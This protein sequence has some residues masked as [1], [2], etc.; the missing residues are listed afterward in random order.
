M[1]APRAPLEVAGPAPSTK[2]WW[3][4]NRA[5]LTLIGTSILIPELLTGS[6]PVVNL[7]NPIAL[8]FLVGLYGGGSLAI[9]EVAVRWG[10]GWGPV[11]ALGGAYGIAEEGLGTKTFFDPSLAHNTFPAPW[12]HW[13][14][15]NW[16]WSVQLT[17]FHAVFSIALPILLVGLVYPETR[18]QRL[19][20]DRGLRWVGVAYGTTVAAMFGLF[21]R[22]YPVAPE[23]FVA[24]LVAIA[25]L[26]GVAARMPAGWVRPRTERP[27][28][29][30]RSFAWAG[31][32]Y[33]WLS[34][35]IAFLFGTVTGNVLATALAQIALG[36]LTLAWL[37]RHLGRSDHARH[38][39]QLAAGLI[40]FLLLFAL[41]EELAGDYGA[42]LAIGA[43]VLLIWRAHAAVGPVEPAGR[44]IGAPPPGAL[45]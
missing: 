24:A 9:R 3:N 1:H 29:P 40:S 10:R 21:D 19:L 43:A 37:L 6:T 23:L 14:G 16:D 27:D 11:L 20:S 8:A 30:A 31:G 7:L 17:I 32:A 5:A 15:V 36:G 41:V 38:L 42:F 34:F 45:G 25:I 44:A 4:R 22:S 12:G 33:V 28:R 35:G 13:L 39:A 26:V 2:R 18:G